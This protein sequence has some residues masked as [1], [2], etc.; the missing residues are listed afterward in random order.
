[1]WIKAVFDKDGF[2]GVEN[3]WVFD[4]EYSKATFAAADKNGDGLLL[5]K[6]CET[7]KNIVLGP[8]QKKNYFNYVLA[9]STFMPAGEIDDFK[10]SMEKGRLVLRFLIE[11]RVPIADDYTMLVIVVAD[12]TNYMQMSVDMD[13]ATVS[14]PENVNVE[15]FAENLDGLTLFR[16]FSLDVK[17]LFVRFKKV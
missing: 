9:N 5:D 6:E 17:G 13:E 8:F 7:I 2:V 3:Q 14:A 11:Y 4:E 16:T 12:Q 10:A 1:M 15:Y